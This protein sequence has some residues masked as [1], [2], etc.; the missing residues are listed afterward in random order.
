METGRTRLVIELEPAALEALT[1]YARE[2][3]GYREK[4]PNPI[5]PHELEEGR[6]AAVYVAELVA[7]ILQQ[8]MAAHADW[9]AERE[10]ERVE[11]SAA[12][13][14]EGMAITI[15]DGLIKEIGA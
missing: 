11:A 1:A 12:R 10:R 6:P 5:N 14:A 9:A 3:Y 13:L 15:E 8:H 4:V 2:A 7:G